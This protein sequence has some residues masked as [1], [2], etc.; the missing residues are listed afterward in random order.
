MIDEK[1]S[2]DLRRGYRSNLFVDGF[3]EL[4]LLAES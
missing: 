2:K 1:A 3:P 4:Q